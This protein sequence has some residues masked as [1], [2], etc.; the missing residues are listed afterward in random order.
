[1]GFRVLPRLRIGLLQLPRLTS[2]G[3]LHSGAEGKRERRIPEG[4]VIVLAEKIL[5]PA[6]NFNPVTDCI[7]HVQ[8]DP[9]VGAIEIAVGQQKRGHEAGVKSKEVAVIAASHYRAGQQRRDSRVR[10]AQSEVA[11]MRSAAEWPCPHQ[12]G[13]GTNRNGRKTGIIAWPDRV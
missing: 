9:L 10:V 11:G 5:K 4:F 12:R 3:E 6:D 13:V 8:I 2:K 1:M 7:A